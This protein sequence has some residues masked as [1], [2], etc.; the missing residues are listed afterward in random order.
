MDLYQARTKGGFGV[1]DVS[2]AKFIA[3][4]SQHLKNSGQIQLP[5]WVSLVKTN[6]AKELPPNDPDW[7][8]IRLASIARKLYL[9]PNHGV[10]RMKKV[11][12]SK[13]RRGSKP[14]RYSKGSGA[15]IRYAVQQLQKLEILE[16]NKEKGARNLTKKGRKELD[17]IARQVAVGHIKQEPKEVDELKTN[18][19]DNQENDEKD[20]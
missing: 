17:L 9:R 8:Y 3:V 6:K 20:I 16:L 19:E 10:R 14:G 15:I 2:A 18:Q 12:S 7:F 1:K 5:K 13:Q 11:Y 4:Y